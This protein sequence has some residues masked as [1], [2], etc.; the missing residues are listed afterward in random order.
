MSIARKF[1]EYGTVY[2]RNPLTFRPERWNGPAAIDLY[3]CY[4]YAL[5]TQEFGWLPLH[6]RL[7]QRRQ[8]IKF[9]DGEDFKARAH[10]ALIPSLWL[11]VDGLKRIRKHE[12]GPDEKHII[13]YDGFSR[14]FYRLDSSGI[15]S[16]KNGGQA[17]VNTDDKGA[18]ILDLEAAFF[19]DR[20]RKTYGSPSVQLSYYVVPD[21]GV[22]ILTRQARDWRDY[23]TILPQE[24]LEGVVI[25]HPPG[26]RGRDMIKAELAETNKRINREAWQM[27][28]YRLNDPRL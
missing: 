12:Y 6:G 25:F 2:P 28:P 20:T 5:D 26:T 10:P 24:R 27:L 11:Q 21:E 4:A 22:K 16:H 19:R 23:K 15:W 3:N 8:I 9:P 13:A 17:A 1:N 18:A 14:H 7:A